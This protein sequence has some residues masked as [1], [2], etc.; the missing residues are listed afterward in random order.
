MDTLS[1][2]RTLDRARINLGESWELAWWC[3]HWRISEDQ[4]VIAIKSAGP[5]AADVAK[6]LGKPN[7]DLHQ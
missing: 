3:R 1:E 7:P 4:L 5:F 2:T 6:Q